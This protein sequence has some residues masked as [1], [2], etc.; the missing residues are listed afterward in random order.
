MHLIA[1]IYIGNLNLG[2]AAQIVIALGVVAGMIASIAVIKKYL[3]PGKSHTPDEA[4]GFTLGGLR[5]MVKEGKM[6][7]EEFDRLKAQVIAATQRAAARD[8]KSTKPPVEHKTRPED[9]H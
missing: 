2:A 6:T 8:K 4:S 5:Q 7:Q 3:F 9:P 1:D